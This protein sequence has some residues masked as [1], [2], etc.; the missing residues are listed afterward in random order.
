MSLSVLSFLG[1][2]FHMIHFFFYILSISSTATMAR[3]KREGIDDTHPSL[4]A[5]TYPPNP[6]EIAPA[7]NSANPPRTT[8]LVSPRADNPALSANGTVSPSDMPRIASETIRGLMRVR[9]LPCSLSL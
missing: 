7:I 2:W 1:P 3:Q 8:T 6:I 5:P 9:V 4:L